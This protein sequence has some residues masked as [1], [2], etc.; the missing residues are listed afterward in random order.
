MAS[1]GDGIGRYIGLNTSNGAVIDENGNLK[2]IEQMGIFGSYRHLWNDQWRSNFTVGYLA[3]DNDTSL[4]GMG[5]T[6]NATSYHV[7]AIYSPLPKLDFG[8][9]FMYADREVESGDDGSMTRIQFLSE[10]RFLIQGVPV[11]LTGEKK[12]DP[13]EGPFFYLSIV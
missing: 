9:E 8:I 6:K 11:T 5:A 2:S 1:W 3:I 10:I 13:F 4:T 7:N 12:T